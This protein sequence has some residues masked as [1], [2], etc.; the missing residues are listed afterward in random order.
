[1]QEFLY[2][3]VLSADFIIV[4]LLRQV[5]LISPIFDEEQFL[6]CVC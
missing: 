5:N 3:L 2:A 6:N 4:A 1:M